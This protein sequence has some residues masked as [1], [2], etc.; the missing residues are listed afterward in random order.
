MVASGF[1][2]SQD[3]TLIF[4]QGGFRTAYYQSQLTWYDRSGKLLGN[5]GK[6]DVYVQSRLSPDEKQVVYESRGTLIPTDR[7]LWLLDMVSGIAS[8]FTSSPG[9]QSNPVWSRM[10]SKSRSLE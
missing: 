4:T 1:E 5:V 6:P 7:Q 2:V 3:G 8:R 10:E 9:Q